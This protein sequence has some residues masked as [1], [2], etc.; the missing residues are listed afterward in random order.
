LKVGRSF[1]VIAEL[2]CGFDRL[3]E[4]AQGQAESVV[5]FG[6]SWL[7]GAG[8]AKMIFGLFRTAESAQ[9]KSQVVMGAGGGLGR[10]LELARNNQPLAHTFPISAVKS[11]S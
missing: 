10:R 4:S 9:G 5:G 11:L 7:Q 2:F 6:E 3:S 1:S 8:L